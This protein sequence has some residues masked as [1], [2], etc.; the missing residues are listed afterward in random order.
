[1]PKL[2]RR[3]FL[4]VISAV[5]AGAATAVPALAAVEA[6]PV[7]DVGT[8]PD[9]I[10]AAIA[11]DRRNFRVWCHAQA[12]LADAEDEKTWKIGKQR[13]S[14]SIYWQGRGVDLS[15][16]DDQRKRLL[17]EGQLSPTQIESEYQD[18]VRRLRTG[19]R[20]LRK[21][22]KDNGLAKL[23]AEYKRVTEAWHQ[24]QGALTTI[25]PT[26]PCGAAALV[27]YVRRDM[28]VGVALWHQR[29]LTNAVKAL[30]AMPAAA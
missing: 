20:A 23:K 19:R 17:Q 8:T 29:A 25:K 4:S 2:D 6:A 14:R 16:I 15:D 1:M 9:P 21:W 13:P 3:N 11:Q 28:K 10:F 7:N 12:K 26:T 30:A 27:E 24:S 18:G 5:A 22:Y